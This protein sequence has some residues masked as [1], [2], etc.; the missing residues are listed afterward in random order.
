MKLGGKEKEQTGGTLTL[1]FS[2]VLLSV[3]TICVLF[4]VIFGSKVYENI[5]QR[6]ELN[7]ETTTALA[8]IS[9]KVKQ[10]DMAD[11]I[12]VVE[13]DGESVLR[14]EETIKNE[15]YETL[16]YSQKGS[17][18][19]LFFNTDSSLA[20]DDGMEIMELAGVE[21]QETEDGM[22]KASIVDSDAYLLLSPRCQ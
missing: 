7:F 18:K 12:S 11:S 1:V 5:S 13:M 2:L 3:L 8:Y 10:H 16:I 6:M 4:T 17:L 21:F 14:I 20:L 19:E 9:N 15:K 22:I